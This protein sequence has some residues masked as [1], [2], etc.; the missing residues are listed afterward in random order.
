MNNLYL[1]EMGELEYKVRLNRGVLSPN[2]LCSF[3][4]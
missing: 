4:M 2:S 3:K 1:F